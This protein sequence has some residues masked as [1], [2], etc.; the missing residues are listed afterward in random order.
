MTVAGFFFQRR[1]K[2]LL[3]L[4]DLPAGV[5]VRI[6]PQRVQNASIPWSQFKGL[7]VSGFPLGEEFFGQ[8]GVGQTRIAL[9]LG[10][11]SSCDSA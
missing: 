5:H 1:S 3:G 2:P 4:L 11:M 9:N 8:P 10:Q 6:D 7:A